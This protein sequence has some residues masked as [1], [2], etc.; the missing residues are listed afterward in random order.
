MYEGVELI[1]IFCWGYCLV[2]VIKVF[3][4][5]CGFKVG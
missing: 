5:I 1:V 2:V 3:S 4:V